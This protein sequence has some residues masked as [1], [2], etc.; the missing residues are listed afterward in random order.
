MTLPRGAVAVFLICAAAWGVTFL[1]HGVLFWVLLLVS[2]MVSYFVLGG[3]I[4]RNAS[5]WRRVYF[6]M[7]EK[8]SMLAGAQA[9]I[10]EAAGQTLNPR[11]PVAALLKQI[12][13]GI[14]EDE[15]TYLLDDWERE[16]QNGVD[17]DLLTEIMQENKVPP[18]DIPARLERLQK[19]MAEPKNY[20]AFFVRCA[21][22]DAIE[23]EAGREQKKAYWKAVLGGKIA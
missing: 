11:G 15:I 13:P 22:G 19:L 16:L 23:A 17:P 21:I 8:Y 6:G 12:Q 3:W 14:T 5:P 10:A 9:Y 18:Q 4:Y 20:N 1:A 7:I 2:A